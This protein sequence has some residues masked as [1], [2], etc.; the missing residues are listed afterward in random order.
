MDR[1]EKWQQR[2]EEGGGSW[3]VINDM[4]RL[5]RILQG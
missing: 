3:N 2:V 4:D 5:E 1:L